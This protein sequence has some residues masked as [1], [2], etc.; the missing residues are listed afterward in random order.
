[1]T[2]AGVLTASGKAPSRLSLEGYIWQNYASREKRPLAELLDEL[3]ATA[4]YAGFQNIELNHG[5]FGPALKDRV[6]ALTRS[7]RLLMPSVY[8]GGAMHE[9]EL[10][11]K[12]IARALEVG[13][14]CKEFKCQAIVNNPD[15][16]PANGRKSDGEL[17]VQAESLNRMGRLLTEQ[18]FQLRVH[19]HTAE[20][21]EGAR[22][23]RHI[24]RNTDPQ[25]VTLCLDLE[26]AFH[27]GV[28]PNTLI[29]EAGS[30]VTETHLR[31]KKRETPL[32]AFEDGD[33]DHYAIAATLKKLK[34]EPLVVIELVHHSDT[35]ITRSLKED[36]RL[37]RI[38][39]ERV[40]S[41]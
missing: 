15:T 34:L 17:A 16:K 22:E 27:A 31:N 4:P 6:L 24:L 10:A 38:Y 9:R 1:M 23:W 26:H 25:Y 11:D 32:E 12:T 29:K 18:G 33:I 19:H 14:I 28:D 7:H 39:A 13:L 3:F 36:L 20:L 5:F 21:A 40:F 30:R 35:V 37:S 41:L 8:V 2:T